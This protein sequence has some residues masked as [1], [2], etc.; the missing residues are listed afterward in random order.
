MAE[1][2]QD[3]DDKTEE[4]TP[5]KR[6]QFRE[7]GQIPH[8]RDL[9]A[10]FVFAAVV[11]MMSF[12]L[13]NLI[14][15]ITYGLR[16]KFEGIWDLSTP[17]TVGTVMNTLKGYSLW[18]LMWVIPIFFVNNI[19]AIVSTF[20]QTQFNF[21][22][23]RLAPDFKR[24]NPIK[25]MANFVNSQAL[26]NLAKSI[27][28]LGA[29]SLVAYLILYSEITKVSSLTF[30][31]YKK[32]WAY[33]G[34]I[35]ALLFWSVAGLLLLIAGI[36][37]VYNYNKIEKSLKMTKKEIKEDYKKR[38]VDPAVKAKMRKM[39][40]D[41]SF[42]QTMAATKN[43][44]VLITNPTHIAIALQ[45]TTGM[46]APVVLAKGKD[47][48][49]LQMKE[50]A[51]KNQVPMVENKPLARRMFPIVEIGMEIPEELYKAVA[52]VIRAIFRLKGQR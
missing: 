8:S 49:A 33:W 35:T 25:G 37:Y 29:V 46:R 28:K 9:T 34:S 31:N 42:A 48:M 45:Y 5:E 36:D 47:Y 39:A 38:E 2:D 41:L 40:R 16:F 23:K 6:E 11:A 18:Y 52:E 10:V 32:S 22:A 14:D 15:K 44:T 4:P 21:S 27:G 1:N 43:A 50:V 17:I 24:L 20:F 30:V 13:P 26:L 51:R 19:A 7:Q 3:S 12:Y